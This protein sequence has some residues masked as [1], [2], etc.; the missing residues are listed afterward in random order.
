M[1]VASR[2]VA[3]VPTGTVTFL[4]TDMEG[5]T[6]RWEDDPDVMQEALARHDTIV[7]AAVDAHDGYV[8][9]T[10]GDGFAVAFALL[11]W[12]SAAGLRAFTVSVVDKI[13]S[14]LPPNPVER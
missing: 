13:G 11:P 14:I 4:F 12:A 5:S 8:F 6:R 3:R 2:S 1:H 10:G 9:A 7:R